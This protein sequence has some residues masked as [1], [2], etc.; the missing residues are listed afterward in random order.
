MGL[1]DDLG[2]FAADRFEVLVGP[3]VHVL[4]VERD[5]LHRPAGGVFGGRVLANDRGHGCVLAKCVCVL[6]EDGV[7]ACASGD[8]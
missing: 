2:G 6:G 5:R 7:A 4:E 8:E 1:L 3:I